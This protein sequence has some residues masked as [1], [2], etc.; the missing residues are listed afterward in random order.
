MNY[1][2]KKLNKIIKTPSS[3]KNNQTPEIRNINYS[4]VKELKS[5][6]QIHENYFQRNKYLD[7]K[8]KD[9]NNNTNDCIYHVKYNKNKIFSK[10]PLPEKKESK[11]IIYIKHDKYYSKD[12]I[13]SNEVSQISKSLF[14]NSDKYGEYNLDDTYPTNDTDNNKNNYNNNFTYT[15]NVD[16][17]KSNNIFK[18]NYINYTIKYK[19]IDNNNNYMKN[20]YIKRNSYNIKAISDFYQDIRNNDDSWF[21]KNFT[22]IS[23][24]SEK[25]TKAK[26]STRKK[27]KL[28]NLK[29]KIQ[30]SK[31]IIIKKF[32]S[33]SKNNNNFYYEMKK[34][35][36]DNKIKSL[37][38]RNNN[39]DKENKFP[40]INKNLFNK[41]QISS[42]K[43]N[44]N[45]S[46]FINKSLN[47]INSDIK[48]IRNKILI[49]DKKENSNSQNKGKSFNINTF[50]KS[51]ILHKKNIENKR[52]IT[53][54]SFI[55]I[56][57]K[58]NRS[59]TKNI[60][61]IKEITSKY[62]QIYK[63]ANYNKIKLN[64]NNS[65]NSSI[66]NINKTKNSHKIY[67]RHEMIKINLLA[68]TAKKECDKCH[69]KIYSHLF[70]IHY[71]S[72]PSEI[73]KWLYLGS[74]A[75]ACDISELRRIRIN[76]ILNCAIE[77]NNK[78]LPKDIKELH[79]KIKDYE[80]FELYNYF[81]K[82]NEFINKCKLEGGVILVHCKYGISRSASFIIAYLIKNMRYTLDY[83][84]KFVSKKRSQIKPN[85]GFIGQLHIYEEYCLG[86]K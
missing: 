78:N 3:K 47:L 19:T 13:K 73:F 10:P 23:H 66:N 26:S 43:E 85:K 6:C 68:K 24:I 65:I 44:S 59:M 63:I 39:K 69:K 11:N 51:N 80:N 62:K 38:K 2:S 42:R 35:G 70:K 52:T 55:P 46:R 14:M 21:K 28:N 48:I 86:K 40:N 8:L 29:E 17:I 75:N 5:A 77:C 41:I 7:E 61:D 36:K 56:K 50:I 37:D 15:I 33:F 67:N 4:K 9:W 83:S 45:R 22:R 58:D 64:I 34:E 16:K 32:N 81:E 74:F 72:H 49:I 79:L 31:P 54:Y 60:N 25:P 53:N 12:K 76:Y 71:N 57:R 20:N 30:L 27:A 82:A 1:I 18:S 84:L